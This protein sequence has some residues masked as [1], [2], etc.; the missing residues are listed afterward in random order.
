[1]MN[2]T[3]KQLKE[4]AREVRLSTEEKGAMRAVLARVARKNRAPETGSVWSSVSPYLFLARLRTYQTVLAASFMLLVALG[5]TVYAAEGALPGDTLYP[6]KTEVNE[7]VRTALAVTDEAKVRL[8]MRLME[9]R[10]EEAEKLSIRTK[11]SP[12]ARELA[13]QNMEKYAKR[14]ETRIGRLEEKGKDD[15]A[16]AVA[17]DFSDIIRKH[18]RILQRD[19]KPIRVAT[20]TPAVTRADEDNEGAVRADKNLSA[21]SVPPTL[22]ETIMK[23]NETK[24]R[25]GKKRTERTPSRGEYAIPATELRT[26]PQKKNREK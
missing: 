14:V 11:V 21:R 3:L 24:E 26:S 1:M 17:Q 12:S 15:K 23:I 18:E 4:A 9:R 6:I 7:R 25:V 19:E 13:T 2:I 22:E 10:L 20:S 8:E 5:G 16:L